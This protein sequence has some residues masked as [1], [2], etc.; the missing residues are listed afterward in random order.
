MKSVFVY[1]SLLFDPV[2]TSLIGE[3]PR[4]V[5]ATLPN[6]RRCK[7]EQPGRIARGPILLQD[8]KYETRG[9]V[10]L[11]LD[12]RALGILDAFES[13]SAGA[14]GYERVDV[15]V[16]TRMGSLNAAV[17]R[18]RSEMIGFAAGEWDEKQFEREHLQWYLEVRIPQL[19]EKWE[20]TGT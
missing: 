20:S 19:K 15:E 11:D 9:R 13:P 18:A 5:E 3:M 16:N 12:D 6:H 10:L 8:P 17:Y 2:V 14:P 4:W 1:G 7:V